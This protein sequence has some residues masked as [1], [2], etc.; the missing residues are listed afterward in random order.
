MLKQEIS[1]FIAK[2]FNNLMKQDKFEL[3]L[4]D[5]EIN[6]LIMRSLR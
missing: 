5:K 1:H 3:I 4:E 6:L 2:N